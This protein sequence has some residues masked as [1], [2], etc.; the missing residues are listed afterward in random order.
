MAQEPLAE[1]S[2]RLWEAERTGQPIAPLTEAD[3]SLTVVDAYR[4]QLGVVERKVAQGEEVVGHKIGLTSKPMQRMLGVGEPDYGH[5]FRSMWYASG[6][7]IQRQL[8]QPRVEP[9]IAFVLR[10]DLAGPGVTLH[11]VLS[12]TEYVVPALEVI[13]SRIAAWRIKLVDTVADNA[14][15]G[16]FVLGGQPSPVGA[17]DLSTVGMVLWKNGEVVETGAGAAVLGHP[18]WG[19]AWLAN[20]L[21]EFGTVLRAGHVVLSGS[22]SAAVPVAAGDAVRAHFGRLGSVEAA[23][24]GGRA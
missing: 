5:L 12:A 10:R 1:W 6:Q 15:A 4:I 7:V 9:E 16:C 21:A 2:T 11:D 22:V 3:P 20:K 24:A 17:V 18:G 13:D 19:V 23:F 8:I 14:S